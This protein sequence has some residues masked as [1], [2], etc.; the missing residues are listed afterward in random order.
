MGVRREVLTP[1]PA[2]A[3]AGVLVKTPNKQ[4]GS[5]ISQPTGECREPC[6]VPE[7]PCGLDFTLQLPHDRNSGSSRD[8]PG[9]EPLGSWA[10]AVSQLY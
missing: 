3:C 9:R 8:R 7:A 1:P 10:A 2:S 5:G 4:G 6:R